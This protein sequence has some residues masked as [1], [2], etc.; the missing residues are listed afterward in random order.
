MNGEEIVDL[1]IPQGITSIGDYAFFWGYSLTSVT[2]PSSVTSIGECAFFS[3]YKLT[4]VTIPSSVT[5]IGLGAFQSCWVLTSVTIPKNVTNIGDYAFEGTAISTV[6]SLIENPFDISENV[7]SKN[8]KM[9]ATLYVPKGT[10]NRYKS[11]PGWKEFLYIEEYTDTNTQNESSDTNLNTFDGI[12]YTVKNDSGLEV[13]GLE[14]GN[15]RADI[16]S[17]VTVEGKTY[18]VTSIGA[19]AFDGR[20]DIDYLSIPGSVKSIGEYAFVNCGSNMTVNIADPEAWCQMELGNEHSSPLSSAKKVLVF[21]KETDKIDIPYGVKSIGSFTFYQCR[22]ISSLSI[23]STVRSIGSSSF[24]DCTNLTSLTLSEGLQSIGGSSFEGCTGLQTLIIPSTVVSISVNAF[25]NCKGV[26][27]V[28]CHAETVPDTDSNAFDATPTEKS[29]L[30]VP[31]NSVEA[32]R[33]TWPWSDFK[34]IVA[35]TTSVE[36]IKF[37]N[38][39]YEI[40]S[41]GGDK[42]QNPSKG[43]NIIKNSDGTIKKVLIK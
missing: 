6:I 22:C 28:Y 33:T 14:A 26:K 37:E 8:T 24:E 23:P 20:S 4:S 17:N 18:Q 34:E 40:H 36:P 30:Y 21:D 39:I 43:I 2:I 29:T 11:T 12:I 42:L 1:K 38:G 27:D 25:R 31:A 7:F 3:C 32:Y 13:I 35:L 10:V 15:T 5:S 19:H 9:N 41:L 16:P